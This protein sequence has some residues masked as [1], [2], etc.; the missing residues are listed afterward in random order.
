MTDLDADFKGQALNIDFSVSEAPMSFYVTGEVF[1]FRLRKLYPLV[2]TY[3]LPGHFL[4]SV[5]LLS[6]E[7][8]KVG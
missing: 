2:F 4:F 1:D 7:I 3:D 8:V 5:F 6:E